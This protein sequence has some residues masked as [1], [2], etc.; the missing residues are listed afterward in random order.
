[1]SIFGEDYLLVEP[2]KLVIGQARAIY[3]VAICF[4][5]MEIWGTRY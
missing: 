2:L 5:L 3:Y 4:G 1:M